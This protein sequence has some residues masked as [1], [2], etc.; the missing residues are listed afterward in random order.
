MAAEDWPLSKV[1]DSIFYMG[2]DSNG[3]ISVVP[4]KY[5]SANNACPANNQDELSFGSADAAFTA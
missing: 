5:W 3:Q 4:S 2:L 1:I